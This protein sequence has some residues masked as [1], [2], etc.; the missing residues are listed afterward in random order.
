MSRAWVATLIAAAGLLG[1]VSPSSVV[2]VLDPLPHISSDTPIR[3]VGMVYLLAGGLIAWNVST[4][5]PNYW[6]NVLVVV[7]ACAAGLWVVFHWGDSSP[8]SA[9]FLAALCILFPLIVGSVDSIKSIAL[10]VASVLLLVVMGMFAFEPPPSSPTVGDLY[11]AFL[12]TIWVVFGVP[13][14][15]VGRE[16]RT[17]IQIEGTAA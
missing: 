7:V 13:L 4:G 14:Y 6:K 10:S 2:G 12:A 16:W 3:S 8:D 15:I 5:R 11:I 1:V 9:V 17:R